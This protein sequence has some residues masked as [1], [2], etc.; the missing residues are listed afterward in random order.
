MVDTLILV[1]GGIPGED[2][3]HFLHDAVSL[4]PKLFSGLVGRK[5]LV[6]D[7]GIAHVKIHEGPLAENPAP[8]LAG[9]EGHRNGDQRLP[10]FHGQLE[11]GG[12]QRADIGIE[13]PQGALRENMEPFAAAD[14]LLKILGKGDHRADILLGNGHTA[15]DPHEGRETAFQ[16]G[17]PGGVVADVGADGLLHGEIIP[18]E[19]VVGNGDCP[20]FQ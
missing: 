4:G 9:A 17:L 6:G 8:P 14:D 13:V 16:V 11:G 10:V 3:V 19:H 15:Q 7:Q 5:G 18:H 1:V 2:A 12:L 20:V